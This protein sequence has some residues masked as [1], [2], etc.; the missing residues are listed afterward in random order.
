MREGGR[1]KKNRK[2]REKNDMTAPYIGIFF[3]LFF[4]ASCVFFSF[5]SDGFAFLFYEVPVEFFFL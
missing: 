3:S 1:E 5:V 4:S 2:K